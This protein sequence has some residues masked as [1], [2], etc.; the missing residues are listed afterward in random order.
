[1]TVDTAVLSFPFVAV[2]D[3]AIST[4]LTYISHIQLTTVVNKK[5]EQRQTLEFGA[6]LT[7]SSLRTHFRLGQLFTSVK[8]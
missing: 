5:P 7:R 2:M 3:P 8:N 4:L 6:N 1:M